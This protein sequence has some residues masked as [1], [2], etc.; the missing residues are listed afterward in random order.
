MADAAT[1]Q[2]GEYCFYVA[3]LPA[4]KGDRLSYKLPAAMVGGLLGGAEGL[5]GIGRQLDEGL[6]EEIK[7]A[8]MSVTTVEGG[9]F[10]V[11]TALSKAY[12]K[13]FTGN[14]SALWQWLGFALKTN[15]ADFFELAGKL[16]DLL[17]KLGDSDPAQQQEA[18]T[19]LQE[20][21]RQFG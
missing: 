14:Y 10:K 9:D 18:Q 15:Y 6:F 3:L 4:D 8:M 21:V 1:I 16:F 2:I 20:L 19:E 11:R 12:N 7:T 5:Q 13:V 17:K